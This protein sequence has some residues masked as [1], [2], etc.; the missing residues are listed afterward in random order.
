MRQ[1][2][3][4]DPDKICRDISSDPETTAA[5][6]ADRHLGLRKF[7]SM[8][9]HTLRAHYA[10][11][12]EDLCEEHA[13]AAATA[14]WKYIQDL[15]CIR[16]LAE[17]TSLTHPPM[18][19]DLRQRAEARLVVKRKASRKRILTPKAAER[20]GHELDVHQIELELQN[21]ELRRT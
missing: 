15:R 12:G 19:G 9:S 8:H 16:S 14:F 3:I 2:L 5:I 11:A 4:V 1:L 7:V 18:T 17:S 6:L 13:R 21:E 20:L 10:R